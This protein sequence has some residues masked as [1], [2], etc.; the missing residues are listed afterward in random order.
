MDHR[1]HNT[2]LTYHFSLSVCLELFRLLITIATLL[3]IIMIV[4]KN[5][6]DDY[7]CVA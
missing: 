6:N 7:D 2:I 1:I 5:T 3:V 4:C